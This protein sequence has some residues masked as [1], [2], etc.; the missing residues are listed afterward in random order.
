M[1]GFADRVTVLDRG[2]VCFAGTVAELAAVGG[3]DRHVLGLGAADHREAPGARRALDPRP[4][5]NRRP[6]LPTSCSPWRP[7]PR[8]APRCSAL[9][10]A[11]AE[12]VL[13]RRAPPIEQAFLAVTGEQAA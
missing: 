9:T 10:A 11:G 8:S 5:S 2:A 3:G 7:A 1:R 12:V 13:P 4:R 6:T